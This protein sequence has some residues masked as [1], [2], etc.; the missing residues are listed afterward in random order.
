MT[1]DPSGPGQILLG[2]TGGSGSGVAAP[3]RSRAGLHK[4]R[5]RPSHIPST[6]DESGRPTATL[7]KSS[8]CKTGA[9]RG[10]SCGASLNYF[11]QSPFDFGERGVEHSPARVEHNIPASEAG[12]MEPEG[13]AQ[14]ALDA[15]TL[16]GLADR[17]R[18]GEPQARSRSC[19]GRGTGKAERGEQGSRK[20]NA[21]VIY[22]AEL[23][24]AQ[25]A[26]RLRVAAACCPINVLQWSGGRHSRRSRSV[27]G[28][29]WRG[30]GPG[31]PDRSWSPC[32]SESRVSWRVYDC[33]VERCVLAY[34]NNREAISTSMTC[35]CDQNL[36]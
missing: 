28:V 23:G 14:T 13:F 19:V 10:R 26:R 15:V 21:V 9:L 29:P 34:G 18:H 27:Y 12:A 31:L 5:S 17:T 22:V 32:G 25:N 16:H 6:W 33:S 7:A 8:V 2:E 1:R 30:G 11:L 20:T 3:S 35:Q 36:V 24:G 4:S